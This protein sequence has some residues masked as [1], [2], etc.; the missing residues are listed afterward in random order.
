[1]ILHLSL[2]QV[3]QFIPIVV[4]VEVTTLEKK[5]DGLPILR[6]GLYSFILVLCHRKVFFVQE[7]F[8]PLDP[9]GIPHKPCFTVKGQFYIFVLQEG[10]PR[11]VV[12]YEDC[13]Y[14]LFYFFRQ[15]RAIADPEERAVFRV[16]TSQVDEVAFMIDMENPLDRIFY[17]R[18]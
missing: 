14:I 8:Q 6:R 13:R 1:M 12:R 7:L 16:G 18:E 9:K 2:P 10:I 11:V 15:L 4:H 17:H 5:D 3:K